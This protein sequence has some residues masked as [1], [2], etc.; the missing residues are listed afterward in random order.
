MIDHAVCVEAGGS[1]LAWECWL[2]RQKWVKVHSTVDVVLLLLG[3]AFGTISAIFIVI[4]WA[5][6]AQFKKEK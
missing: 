4:F 2:G 1:L 5:I 3:L 6:H